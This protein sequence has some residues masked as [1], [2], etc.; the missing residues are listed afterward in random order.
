MDQPT[1]NP[2][3]PPPAVSG[4]S[5]PNATSRERRGWWAAVIVFVAA[6]MIIGAVWLL[7]DADVGAEEHTASS[8]AAIVL[9][10]AAHLGERVIVT[11]RVEDLLTDRVLAVGS[12][13]IANDLLVLVDAGASIYGYAAAPGALPPVPTGQFYDV[14]DV[15]QFAGVVREFDRAVLTEE[16][17]L[18]LNPELFDAWEGTPALVMDRLDVAIV[19]SLA[20]IETPAPVETAAP[21]ETAAPA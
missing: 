12:D 21:L 16:L 4:S 13:L 6:V 10:P 1:A 5:R 9:D 17:G 3:L 2:N 14:G 8:V 19:R 7:A 18:V 11:A 15:A 20:T